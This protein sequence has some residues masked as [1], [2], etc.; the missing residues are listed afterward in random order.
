MVA[1]QTQT[2]STQRLAVACALLWLA[3]MGAT[4][5]PFDAHPRNRVQWLAQSSG[6]HLDKPGVIVGNNVFPSDDAQQEQP[7][8]MEIWLSADKPTDRHTI[9]TFYTGER[10]AHFELRQYRT[11]AVI[12]YEARD[13]HNEQTEAAIYLED[14]F[15]GGRPTLL[16]VTSGAKGIHIFLDGVVRKTV[17][18]GHLSVRNFS[19]KLVVGTSPWSYDPWAGRLY[20][21]SLYA[22]EL[23]A[24]AVRE[25][26][27]Q[28]KSHGEI[29]PATR[30]L[31]ITRF[32]FDERAGFVI[33]NQIP[34]APDLSVPAYFQLPEKAMLE[35]P[36][37]E[38]MPFWVR[39]DDLARN[40]V[41]FVPLG[42]LVCVYFL[43]WHSDSKAVLLTVL[44]GGT[45]SLLIEVLQAFI[46]QRDSGVTD[47]ITNTLGTLVG[48]LL[49]RRPPIKAMLE[50]LGMLRGPSDGRP[51]GR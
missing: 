51:A 22:R 43:R 9:L 3:M 41:G 25:H 13:A 36:W 5:W 4:L 12:S 19:G 27:D 32:P 44:L 48:A 8:S 16:T 33:H 2:W 15:N 38:V 30:D 40:I 49:V 17:P 24:A 21:L 18:D 1:I 34:G 11:A 26:Y 47:I 14:V 45:T 35:A 46:P 37:K 20:G 42:M 28:W 29:V 6:V 39:I 23:G 31:V 50:N 7:C 10:P